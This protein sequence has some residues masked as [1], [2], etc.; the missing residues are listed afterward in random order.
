MSHKKSKYSYEMLWNFFMNFRAD[1]YLVFFGQYGFEVFY[2][3]FWS[4]DNKLSLICGS[5]GS[6]SLAVQ[7]CDKNSVIQKLLNSD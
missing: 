3:L 4:V 1:R 6:I 2:L 5:D 7:R